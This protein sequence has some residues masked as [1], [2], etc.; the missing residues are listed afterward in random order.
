MTDSTTH[1]PGYLVEW[2]GGW[3]IAPTVEAS[4]EQ[5]QERGLTGREYRITPNHPDG[6]PVYEGGSEVADLFAG[7]NP[8]DAAPI[9][10]AC[11]AGLDA[12]ELTD[13]DQRA[14]CNECATESPAEACIDA[15][16]DPERW[17]VCVDG[18]PPPVTENADGPNDD[19]RLHAALKLARVMRERYP[20]SLI[21]LVIEA[22]PTGCSRCGTEDAG[23]FGDDPKTCVDC[24][25][26]ASD[27]D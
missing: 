23:R 5:A 25:D 2:D 19:L 3:L 27:D 13:D 15:G 24:L 4:H 17:M 8:S 6:E 1:D 21:T 22:R 26:T 11:G 16:A 20:D 14:F 12:L 10:P 9:C 18:G 7:D